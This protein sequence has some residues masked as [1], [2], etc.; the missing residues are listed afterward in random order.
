M[1]CPPTWAGALYNNKVMSAPA[2]N[3]PTLEVSSHCGPFLFVLVLWG[4]TRELRSLTRP[5]YGQVLAIGLARV[6]YG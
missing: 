1:R 5:F 6:I 3:H 2:P 4:L